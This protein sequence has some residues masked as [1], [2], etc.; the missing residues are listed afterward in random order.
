MLKGFLSEAR[1]AYKREISDIIANRIKERL[2]HDASSPTLL[3]IPEAQHMVHT[4]I[5]PHRLL[6]AVL[7]LHKT[8]QI[9]FSVPTFR[10]YSISDS[11]ILQL[12]L[13][14]QAAT[15]ERRS[16]AMALLKDRTP[17]LSQEEPPSTEKG[18]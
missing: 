14:G 9:R 5:M 4:G 15:M 2:K 1:Q 12:I 7:S 16:A 13:L 10:I 17:R 3:T 18:S 8:E 11:N 6:A